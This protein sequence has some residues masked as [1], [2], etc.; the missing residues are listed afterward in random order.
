MPELAINLL[1]SQAA[2]GPSGQVKV[3]V[4]SGVLIAVVVVASLIAAAVRHRFL[5]RSGDQGH[6][7][8]FLESLRG[9]RDRGEITEEEFQR[10]RMRLVEAA[11][12]RKTNKA[13]E[14]APSAQD[15]PP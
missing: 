7:H 12:K 15:N 10:T 14:A 4:W 9:M 2:P 13:A 5:G 6:G 8:G 11:S 1:L 3:L